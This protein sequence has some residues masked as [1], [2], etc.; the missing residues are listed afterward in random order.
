MDANFRIL[1][2]VVSNPGTFRL[3]F[4]NTMNFTQKSLSRK[5]C[6]LFSTPSLFQGKFVHYFQRLQAAISG[7]QV[8]YLF[9]WG[10]EKIQ[11][12]LAKLTFKNIR[13]NNTFHK[14]Y[15]H[16]NSSKTRHVGPAV[17]STSVYQ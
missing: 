11:K 3:L 15:L 13:Q 10:N 14:S 6:S 12:L 2:V 4:L 16:S 7:M 9:D 8:S 5:I 17:L 1:A